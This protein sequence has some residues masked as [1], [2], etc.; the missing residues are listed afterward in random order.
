MA[1]GIL[2]EDLDDERFDLLSDDA[3]NIG[4]EDG[5][6]GFNRQNAGDLQYFYDAG[7]DDG[8]SDQEDS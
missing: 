7:Y 4:Y 8:I 1:L 6:K 2:Y 3:Y 5:L